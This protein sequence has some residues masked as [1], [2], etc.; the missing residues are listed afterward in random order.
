M[1]FDYDTYCYMFMIPIVIVS[2]YTVMILSHY[3]FTFPKNR[4]SCYV[5]QCG[6]YVPQWGMYIPQW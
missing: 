2:L 1:L 6:I 4:Y 5:P 3:L